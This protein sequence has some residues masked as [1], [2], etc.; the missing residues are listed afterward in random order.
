MEA[1]Q[2]TD[3]DNSILKCYVSTWDAGH[4]SIF[5]SKYK[6]TVLE[7]LSSVIM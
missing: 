1:E 6:H 7:D 3:K 4:T 5:N 2:Y